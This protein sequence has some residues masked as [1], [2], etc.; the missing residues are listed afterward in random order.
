MAAFRK[1]V[2]SEAG[3]ECDLQ[4]SL[5]GF[6]MVFHDDDLRRLCGLN[7][8]VDSLD[9]AALMRLHVQRTRECIPRLGDL[10]K[11]VDGSVPLLLELKFARG[12]TERLCASVAAAVRRYGGPFGVMSF[13]PVVGDWFA[14]HCPQ[15]RRGLVLD[16][17]DLAWERDG[18][19]ARSQCDFVAVK[20]SA[21]GDSWVAELRH[22]GIDV[23]CWTVR[24]PK[25]RAQAAV[26]ADAL[27]WE[28]DGRP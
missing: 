17:S 16:G 15:I 21:V 20:T 18:K 7:V 28:A 27:I 9:A 12:R 14:T 4:L 23:L 11:M 22:D 19:I 3:I 6:P 26:H 1:A 25:Q 13:E 2:E 5:D 24:N 10:L 8:T